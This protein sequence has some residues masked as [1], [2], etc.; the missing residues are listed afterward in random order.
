M[1][2]ALKQGG[3]KNVM[4]VAKGGV[5]EEKALME[6]RQRGDEGRLSCEREDRV[7]QP[8][9]GDEVLGGSGEENIFRTDL[10]F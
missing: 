5:R 4:V 8:D 1:H 6:R 10:D 7:D 3:K 9:E 2:G